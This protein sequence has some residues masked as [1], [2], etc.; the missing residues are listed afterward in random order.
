MVLATIDR[1]WVKTL[2]QRFRFE[3]ETGFELA[4][5]LAQGILDVGKGIFSLDGA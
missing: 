4:P 3:L 1:L 2:E 5:R